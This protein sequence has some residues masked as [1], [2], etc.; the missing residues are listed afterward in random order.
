MV[1]P[2]LAL[3]RLGRASHHSPL[4]AF[5]LPPDPTTLLHRGLPRPRCTCLVHIVASWSLRRCRGWRCAPAAWREAGGLPLVL[6]LIVYIPGSHTCCTGVHTYTDAFSPECCTLRSGRLNWRLQEGKFDTGVMVHFGR[7][8][9]CDVRLLVK[10]DACCVYYATH[11]PNYHFLKT[12]LS[13]SEVSGK[14]KTVARFPVHLAET[15]D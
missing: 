2:H 15:G 10:R 14:H 11:I 7:F 5:R 8:P 4:T 12:Y 3:A 13:I 1:L 9:C 6:L